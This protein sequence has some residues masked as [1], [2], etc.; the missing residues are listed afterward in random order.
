MPSAPSVV[1][2]ALPEQF[3]S[4]HPN[5]KLCAMWVLHGPE[6][7]SATPCTSAPLL[8]VPGLRCFS[9]REDVIGAIGRNDCLLAQFGERR[10]VS[11][12]SL[13]FAGEIVC[14]CWGVSLGLEGLRTLPKSCSAQDTIQDYTCVVLTLI[15]C[16][17]YA[18]GVW[19]DGFG[20]SGGQ[21]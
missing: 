18:S 4:C 19:K 13:V 21:V 14:W 9:G 3:P 10:A 8:C 7:G 15:Q 11:P 2:G 6:S 16:C 12:P 20:A 17:W 5:T 1:L